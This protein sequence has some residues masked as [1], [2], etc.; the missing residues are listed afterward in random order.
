MPRDLKRY[1]TA[2]ANATPE[3]FDDA[4]NMLLRTTTPLRDGALMELAI[5]TLI[6]AGKRRAATSGP[7]R[8]EFERSG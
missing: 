3:D 7:S 1:T 8:E 6:D 2:L 5:A 4:A